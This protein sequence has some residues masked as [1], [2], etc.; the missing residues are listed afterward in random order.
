MFIPQ[1]N[2]IV[3]RRAVRGASHL[4]GDIVKAGLTESQ[5]RN[6]ANHNRETPG[7]NYWAMPASEY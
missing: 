4:R 2:W 5:A 1:G 7:Y 6:I 3:V